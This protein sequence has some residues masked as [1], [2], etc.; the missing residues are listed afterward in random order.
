MDSNWHSFSPKVK[1]IFLILYF[2]VSILVR[3]IFLIILIL[4]LLILSCEKAHSGFENKLYLNLYLF[5][6]PIASKVENL[7]ANL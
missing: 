3:V 7:P 5:L 4:F 1:R 6:F 2:T